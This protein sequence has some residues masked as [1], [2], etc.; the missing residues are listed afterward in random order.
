MMLKERLILHLDT[1]IEIAQK[2]E[3]VYHCKE[4]SIKDVC[5]ICCLVSG[6]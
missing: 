4:A 6:I 5:N 3:L 2:W 1:A